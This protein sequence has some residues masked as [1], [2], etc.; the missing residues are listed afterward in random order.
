MSTTFPDHPDA[1]DHSPSYYG[2]NSGGYG[3]KKDYGKS[4]GYQK[5]FGGGFQ[6]KPK[7]E[8]SDPNLYLAYAVASNKGIPQSV[9]QDIVEVAKLLETKGFTVRVGGDNDG[10]DQAVENAVSRKE[11]ILPWK[12]FNE[13]ESPFTWSI[14]A[15]HHIAKKFSPIYDTIPD[16]VKKFLHQN[17]R[18]VMGDKMRSPIAFLICWSEDGCETLREKTMRTGFVAHQI[19]ITIGACRQVFNFGKPDAKKRL[20]EYIEKCF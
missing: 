15:S 13:K 11:L 6:R 4:G 16:G 19:G 14:E 5:S 3:Q 12:G 9:I 2:G 1:G 17:A 8:E 20:I 10:L 18:L 7:P